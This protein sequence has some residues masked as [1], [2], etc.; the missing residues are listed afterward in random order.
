MDLRRTPRRYDRSPRHLAL[1]HGRRTLHQLRSAEAQNDQKKLPRGHEQLYSFYQPGL[2]AG[3]HIINVTQNIRAGDQ[4]KRVKSDHRFTVFAPR[5]SLP[6][7]A[8]YSF[9]PP[10]GHSDGVEIVPNVVLTDPTLPWERT[11]SPSTERADPKPDDYNRNR[12]PW[13]AVLLFTQEEL[14]LNQADLASVVEKTSVKDKATQSSTFSISMPA[15]EAADGSILQ[16]TT[17]SIPFDP[18]SDDDAEKADV[19]FLKS[20]LFNALFTQYDQDAKPVAGQKSCYVYHHRYLAHLRQ[21]NMEGTAAAATMEDE[22]GDHSYSVVVCHRTGP[23][24]I[25]KPTTVVAHLVNIEAVEGLA[26][27]VQNDFVAMSS[28]YSWE[29]TCLPSGSLNVQDQFSHL[30]ETLGVLKPQLDEEDNHSLQAKGAIGD[31]LSKR[32]NDGYSMMRYRIQT[33]E[34]TAAFSRSPFTPTTVDFPV[35]NP[36]WPASSTTGTKLQIL[37]RQ[38]NIMDLTYSTAWTLGKTLGLANPEFAAAL[39]RVRKQIYDMGVDQAKTT[40]IKTRAAQSEVPP[41]YKSAEEVLSTL[42]DT[43]QKVATLPEKKILQQ[44]SD[45]MAHRWRRPMLPS[46]D[47]SY[48]GPEISAVVDDEFEKT[49]KKIAS[50]VEEPDKPYNEHNTPYSTDWMIVLHWILDR[51]YLVDVPSHYLITDPSH[52]PQEGLRFFSIDPQWVEAMID[53]GLSLANHLDQTDDRVRNAI[54]R[55]F[56][57]YLTTEIPV[58]GYRPPTPTYGFYIRSA[59]VTKFPDLIVDLEPQPSTDHAPVVLRHDVVEPST[60]LCLMREPPKKGELQSLFLREPPHQQYFAAAADI[61]ADKV[62]VFYKRAYTVSPVPDANQRSPFEYWCPRQNPEP[63]RSIYIWGTSPSATDVRCLNIENLAKDYQNQLLTQYEKLGHKD[64]YTDTIP[65][66][67]LMA[68]QLNEPQFQLEI[69]LPTP[70]TFPGLFKAT[71]T[72]VDNAPR[73]LRV[74]P[75]KGS[76]LPIQPPLPKSNLECSPHPPF[77]CRKRPVPARPKYMPPHFQIAKHDPNHQ[78]PKLRNAVTIMGGPQFQYKLYAI[79]HPNEPIP[80]KIKER[81]DLVFSI[82]MQGIAGD[83][84]MEYMTFYVPLDSYNNSLIRPYDG[85]G[86]VMLSNL[87]FNVIAQFG[88]KDDRNYLILTLKPR[89]TTGRVAVRKIQEMSFMLRGVVTYEEETR[90][91][92]EVIEKYYMQDG[93]SKRFFADL[94]SG[95]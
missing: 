48:K 80:I 60:L 41:S 44:K 85:P 82:V 88:K 92:I 30:G 36:P 22:E 49:A 68:I 84:E 94:K 27:P 13:M 31:R 18:E 54:K 35:E 67:A 59:L 29:Y 40:V 5:F 78:L 12:V 76:S 65:N 19:I 17:T 8:I 73:V 51:Y 69:E 62:H 26:Y 66:A 89:N 3:P 87:R 39:S 74:P 4:E 72:S 16:R 10:Q 93:W 1:R 14:H 21:I 79:D 33:G 32:L 11:G 15:K 91:R 75:K 61:A 34:I 86:P 56:N 63:G 90:T 7:G 57:W 6:E 45:G 43:L 95:R 64:W 46:P 38:L 71:R 70:S 2:T 42:A 53:G 23:L 24:D 58:L 55:A 28:L 9:Y 77:G 52:L 50:S 25:T 20:K 47:L 37:D 83:F 81:Q